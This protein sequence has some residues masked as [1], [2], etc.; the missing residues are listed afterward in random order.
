M[1]KLFAHIDCNDEMKNMTGTDSWNILK[2][3]LD[4]V[5]NKYVPIKKQ[6]KR[7]KKKHL[8]KQ[9]FKKIIYKQDMWRVYKHTGQDKDYEVYKEALNAASN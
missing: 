7:S 9:A 5:I 1:N 4:S 2:S 8:S 6:G 3:E